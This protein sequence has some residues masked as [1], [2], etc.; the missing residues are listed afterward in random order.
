[1]RL[2]IGCELERPEVTLHGLLATGLVLLLEE[3]FLVGSDLAQVVRTGVHRTGYGCEA[4]TSGQLIGVRSSGAGHGV[5]KRIIERELKAYNKENEE[6]NKILKSRKTELE[7]KLD[8]VR[9]RNAMG[10]IDKEDY[11]VAKKMLL[12]QIAQINDEFRVVS[13]LSS[14][15]FSKVDK[16]LVTAS[17]LGSLWNKMSSADRKKLEF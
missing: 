14:N 9:L 5:L 10:E 15:V 4:L 7:G 17:Q 11:E 1:M 12:E 6:N 2:I 13:E 16:A 3:G 8:K